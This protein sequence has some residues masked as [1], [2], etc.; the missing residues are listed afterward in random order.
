MDISFFLTNVYES[1]TRVCI[2]LK[3]HFAPKG[4]LPY[5]P[6][7]NFVMCSYAVSWRP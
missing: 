7:T 6:D 5:L 4:H 1:A 3:E 2:V